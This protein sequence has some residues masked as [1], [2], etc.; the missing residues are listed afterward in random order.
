[1]RDGLHP[2]VSTPQPSGEPPRGK[3]VRS[4]YAAAQVQ[5]TDR[6]RPHAPAQ[7]TETAGVS[8]DPPANYQAAP[9][10]SPTIPYEGGSPTGFDPFVSGT[11]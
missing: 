9:E 4:H 1:M 8:P 7:V 5:P 6:F 3:H 11:F 10:I 2:A